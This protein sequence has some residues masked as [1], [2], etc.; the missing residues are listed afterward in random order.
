MELNKAIDI[1][2]KAY[3][4]SEGVSSTDLKHIMKSPAHYR[5]WKDNPVEDTSALLF[6][7]AVHKYVLEKDDFY[8]EFAVAPP[9]DRRTKAGKEEWA[10]FEAY[11]K[12][13]DI[14]SCDDM[15]KIIDMDKALYATPFIDVLLADTIREKSYYTVDEDTGLLLKCRPDIQA[16]IGDEHVLI[17]YKSCNDASSE[18]FMKDAI[19]LGY[20][21]QLAFYKD[22]LD[23]ITGYEHSVMFIAQEKIAPYCANILQ[24]DEYF[25]KSGRDMYKTMLNTYKECTESGVWYGYLNNEVN[26]LGLPAWLQK[27]YE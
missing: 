1:S 10:L 23:K 5:Y 24:A 19:K 14:I 20:D 25:I 22:I 26:S 18:A 17:D 8:S 3:H 12:D 16:C 7:R 27:Q 2:N 21:L 13:E 6:G 11:H 15:Q 4:A 9:I